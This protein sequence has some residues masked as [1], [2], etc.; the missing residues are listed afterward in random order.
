MKKNSDG[1][2]KNFFY[3]TVYELL[4]ILLPLLTSPYI[5][6]VL[7]AEKLGIYS[8][9]YAI[10][11]YFQLFA[12]LGIK[13]H[14]TRTIASVKNNQEELN[15]K[16]SEIL[17]FHILFSIICII[18][19]IVYLLVFVKSNFIISL[20]QILNVLAIMVDVS[21][22]FF[23]MEKFKLSTTINSIIRIITVI[24]IFVL[25]KE[26]A[27]LWKY[28][29]IMS[30]GIFLGQLSLWIYIP[31]YVKFVKP[32]IR[33]VFQHIK[34]M[35]I[36]FLPILAVS[37]FRYMDKIMLGFI[38]NKIQ[39]GLYENADKVIN[40][41]M[42]VIISFSTVMLP[43]ITT[44]I[45]TGNKERS[46]YYTTLSYRYMELIAIGMCFG[47]YCVADLFSLIF[48]GE[49]FISCGILIKILAFTIPFSTYSCIMRTQYL[50]PHKK[51]KIYVKSMLYGG[52]LNLLLNYILIN[53]Y[54]GVGAA[55]ATLVSEIFVM[56]VQMIATKNKLPHTKYI[57]SFLMFIVFG[58]I[59]SIIVYC[60]NI[61]LTASVLS[62]L[63]EITI[64]AIIYCFLSIIYL[65]VI[66]DDL[67]LKYKNKFF[68][69]GGKYE[70]KR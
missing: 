40:M 42:T 37:L 26:K 36:L 70:N 12:A 49:E 63:I 22:F 15:K 66:K 51:D 21:W 7:G 8:L 68:K 24:L 69:R 27:D 18:L 61:S 43:R 45:S 60:I 34:P 31:K 28:T 33:N 2:K 3:Q 59:M 29:L 19:Y 48:W 20:I 4:L 55:I 38:T 17:T 23:G 30:S 44:L 35:L 58:V 1:L 39:V 62:L 64:G 46:E 47:L 41:P 67:L 65:L 5:A 14:G 16:Y 52:V 6:R 50:M 9:S 56:I 10:A 54:S 32:K 57:K 53:L 13:Y 11:Y 25:V